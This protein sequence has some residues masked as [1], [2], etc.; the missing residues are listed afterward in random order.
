MES[1]PPAVETQEVAGAGDA[2][3]PASDLDPQILVVRLKEA[4]RTIP[5]RRQLFRNFFVLV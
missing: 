2:S 3:A 1:P 4:S 5:F